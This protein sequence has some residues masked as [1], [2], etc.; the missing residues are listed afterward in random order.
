MLNLTGFQSFLIA[1]FEC[2]SHRPRHRRRLDLTAATHHDRYALN[3]YRRALS[4][5]F[6]TVRDG[7]RWHLI[8]KT[9][10]HYDF[11][12]VLP[13]IRAARIAGVQVLWDICH[14]GWP[15]G[16]D[17]FSP[18]FVDRFGSL[19]HAFAQVL[20]D[21]TDDIIFITPI[22][23]PSYLAWAAGQAGY[24]YPYATGRGAELKQQLLRAYIAGIEAIRSV[25]PAARIVVTD[26]LI[27][28]LPHPESPERSVAARALQ[29]AQYEF[30]DQLLEAGEDRRYL[31]IVGACYYDYNQWYDR[32]HVLS[33]VPLAPHDPNRRPLSELLERLYTRYD[34]PLFLAETSTELGE[35]VALAR[36]V[37]REVACAQAAG[38]PVGGICWYPAIDHLGWDDDRPCYH[39]LWG[40]SDVSGNREIFRPLLDVLQEEAVANNWMREEFISSAGYEAA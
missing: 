39:G 7:I 21:E 25:Q 24:I 1:G 28:V 6:G 36:M 9:A 37:C 40:K 27:H 30:R 26:P 38:V 19:A 11:K 18:A 35:R 10:Y 20:V 22:N 14:F 8:E 2:A 33:N 31:D 4:D 3:D 15:D 17:I 23:E 34:R 5:G 16:L 29:E 32:G 13:M 12:S